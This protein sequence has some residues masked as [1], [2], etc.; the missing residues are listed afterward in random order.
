MLTA[1]SHAT[2][3]STEYRWAAHA[4]TIFIV[5]KRARESAGPLS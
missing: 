5:V 1:L 3:Y 4:A 2:Q